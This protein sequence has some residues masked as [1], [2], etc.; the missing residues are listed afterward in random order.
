MCSD[1]RGGGQYSFIQDILST[2]SHTHSNAACCVRWRCAISK[3]CLHSSLVCKLRFLSHW[4][5]QL[6]LLH[7]K[8][9]GGILT[10]TEEIALFVFECVCVCLCVCVCVCVCWGGGVVI[11]SH[12]PWLFIL[13]PVAVTSFAAFMFFAC[14]LSWY[15]IKVA[16]NYA[17]ASGKNKN[18]LQD[19]W[20]NFKILYYYTASCALSKT[21][22]Y[23]LPEG[24]TL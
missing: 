13:L 5:S 23:I 14:G 7:V 9:G 20:I 11:S 3:N 19:D 17:S 21:I 16:I 22:T 4:R 2:K 6:M 15:R 18:R 24:L 12:L 10:D 1:L 8:G